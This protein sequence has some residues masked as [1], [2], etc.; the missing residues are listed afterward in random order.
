[1]AIKLRGSNI[2]NT[3]PEQVRF[4]MLIVSLIPFLKSKMMSL[5]RKASGFSSLAISVSPKTWVKDLKKSD[6]NEPV[7]F[8]DIFK[9]QHPQSMSF[10]KSDCMLW[11]SESLS[12]V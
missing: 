11:L 12:P 9:H 1:V 2:L 10:L 8:T 5:E 3:I 4:M 6:T 7:T